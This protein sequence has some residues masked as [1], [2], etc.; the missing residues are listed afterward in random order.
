MIRA[1][2]VRR[3]GKERP[4]GWIHPILT[5]PALRGRTRKDAHPAGFTP[6]YLPRPAGK[7]PEGHPFGWIHPILTFPARRGRNRKNTHPAGSTP[8]YPSP[9]G[10]EGTGTHPFGWIHPI[11]PSLPGGEGTGTHP[12]GWIHPILTFPARRGRNRNTPIRLDPPHPNLPR[13][14]GKR[15]VRV[16]PTGAFAH[17]DNQG[18]VQRNDAFHELP[19]QR[20]HLLHF[21]LRHLED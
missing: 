21:S 4:S 18:D 8:S 2:L 10:G 7:E 16:G 11:L 9:P 6:S 5:F 19:D 15:S 12:F 3:L 13:P 20:A 14:A 1:S 17:V